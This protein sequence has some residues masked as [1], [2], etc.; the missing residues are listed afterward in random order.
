M[1]DNG[2]ILLHTAGLTYS[3]KTGRG[4]SGI[5]ITVRSGECLAFLGRNGSGKSTLIKILTGLLRPDTGTVAVMGQPLDYRGRTHAHHMGIMLDT[6]PH[7]DSLSGFEN[8]YFTLSACSVTDPEP[9]ISELFD[10]ASLS[11]A[12][13]DH[14]A[15][16]SFGMRRKLGIIEALGH[17]PALLIL[18]EPTI[19]LDPPFELALADIIRSRCLRGLATIIA[20]NDA[21]FTESVATRCMFIHNGHIITEGTVR[22][23]IESISPWQEI[24]VT[25]S[26]DIGLGEP[27]IPGIRSYS[28]SG[29]TIILITERDPSA[30][31]RVVEW[32]TAN[33]AS[34]G[35]LEVRG[36]SLRDAFL[37]H[38]GDVLE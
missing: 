1:N 19:G 32:C 5:D 7:W 22:D 16:Y 4:I 9:R 20:G 27:P 12:A 2:D 25:I 34:V 23:L 29:R 30:A 21:T 24:T 13:H 37:L 33:G 31:S 35:S 38:T 28:Q 6:A 36:S 10:T 26:V 8:A 18:D 11:D 17:D 14:V 3:Y 15:T